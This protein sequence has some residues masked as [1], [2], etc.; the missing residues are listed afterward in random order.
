MMT[1]RTVADVIS[2]LPS[3]EIQTLEAPCYKPKEINIDEVAP[4][5]DGR[6]FM[7]VEA[8]SQHTADAGWQLTLGLQNAGYLLCGNGLTIN[9]QDT[10]KILQATKPSTVIV[11]D[12]REWEGR[13]AKQSHNK[14]N[15]TFYNVGCL[16]ERED[17]FKLT[18]LKDCQQNPEYHRQSADEMGV[19]GWITY[20][21]P[22]I[23][24]CVAP[25][26]R[27]EHCVRTSHSI[28]PEVVPTYKDRDYSCIISGAFSQVYPLRTKII[29]NRNF[30]R[31]LHYLPHPGYHSHGCVTPKYLKTLSQYKIAICTSSIY[32]YT[33]RK[34]IESTVC[35]CRVITDLPIDDK[36]PIIEENLYR[37]STDISMRDL[38]SVIQMLTDNYDSEYQETLAIEATQYYDYKEV[39]LRLAQNIE[40]LKENYLFWEPF[41][42]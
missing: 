18:V 31:G 20:Y 42:R 27:K 16:K 36:L 5:W 24:K 34:L 2:K 12:K 3:L 10:P 23:V 40:T 29:K 14:H 7:A 41:L 32:G 17:L 28:D 26:V 33:L 4:I 13:T 30:F 9:E 38:S 8:M 37:V 39:G 21:H 6:I 15:M 1:M 25:Y 19:H 35:G 22:D 11:Q